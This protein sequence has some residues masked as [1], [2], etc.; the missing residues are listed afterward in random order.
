MESFSVASLRQNN[1]VSFNLGILVT[2]PKCR[3]K[4]HRANYPGHEKYEREIE[5]S[6]AKIKGVSSM[7]NI[8]DEEEIKR[9]MMTLEPKEEKFINEN[10]FSKREEDH[11]FRTSRSVGKEAVNLDYYLEKDFHQE[12]FKEAMS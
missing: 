10:I 2:C 3:K 1:T 9:R 8:V 12:T 4:F 6:E 7:A 5:L 11:L